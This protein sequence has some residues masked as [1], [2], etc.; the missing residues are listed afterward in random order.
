MPENATLPKILRDNYQKYGEDVVA[1]RKKDFGIWQEYS[2]RDY[3]EIVKYFGLGL[4]QIGF[5]KGDVAAIVGDTD[6]EWFF[7]ELSAQ[8]AGG[9]SVGLFTDGLPSELEFIIVHSGATVVVAKDQ[10][11]VDKIIE[12]KDRIPGLKKIIYWEDKGIWNYDEPL[13]MSFDE[14][15]ELG[16]KLEAS[17]PG[18]FEELVDRGNEDDVA[19]LSYTSGTTGRPKGVMLTHLNLFHY[20]DVLQQLGE[21]LE[22]KDYVAYQSPAWIWEQW[23]GMCCGL[24]F[25]MVVHFCEEPETVTHDI[26]EIAPSFL[27]LGPR[28][29][30]S[31]ASTIQ[32]KIRDTSWW[33]R[34]CYNWGMGV[35]F[36]ICDLRNDNKVP[37]GLLKAKHRVAEMIVLRA[38]RDRFGIARARFLLTGSA[39]MS[40]D[41]FRFFHAMGAFIRVIYGGTEANVVSGTGLTDFD[42][43]TVGRIFP[44]VEVKISDEGEMLVR[45][46][47]VFRG[48]LNDPEA[49][50]ERIDHE[51]WFHTGDAGILDDKN[52]LVF[53]DRLDEL[54]QLAGGK[55]FSPQ[56]IETKLRFS[57]YIEDAYVIG[58]RDKGFV[59]AIICIDFS[60]V[61]KWAED[62]SLAFTTFVDLSQKPDVREL[63]K[64]EV[65]TLNDNLPGFARIKKYI[66]LH[67][68]FDADDAELTRTR[69]LKRGVMSQRYRDI[70]EATYGGKDAF[71]VDASVTYRDGRKGVISAKL[72]I[73][74]A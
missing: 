41:I 33:K 45:G 2:W 74:D 26:R 21:G 20:A 25:P 6:P 59:S 69:K 36:R 68:T 5:H 55:K 60:N 66:N 63:I 61:A 52:R 4:I 9:T 30:E 44:G 43:E 49:T 15:K 17:R 27:L 19:I 72:T 35:G 22:G 3:Y 29:W 7:A 64:G 13:L 14:V 24:L 47:Q 70:I 39:S 8:A 38:L 1:L 40:P 53:W 56:F 71:N 48:Y 73:N 62:R 11:Q 16:E 37:S 46:A 42:F 31:F 65:K 67:K 57:P 18:Y 58:D 32:V 54:M 50:E 12:I 51:G 23:A 28:Q 10:E 34:A